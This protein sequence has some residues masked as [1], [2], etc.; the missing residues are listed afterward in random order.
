M[1]AVLFTGCVT[2]N[3]LLA[4]TPFFTAKS[5]YI[6]GV[7]V[8]KERI[9]LIQEKGE[10]GKDLPDDQKRV[11]L[12]QL[13]EEYL[14]SPNPNVREESI[15]SI[16]QLNLPEGYSVIKTATH[17]EIAFVRMAACD[18]LSELKTDETA[19]SLRH[20]LLHDS[21]VDVRHRAAKN[22]AVYKNDQ[23]TI[24]ALGMALDDKAPG[25]QFQAMQ[26]LKKVTDQDFGNDIMRWKQFVNGES[27]D[28][29]RKR[30]MTERLYLNQLPM[31]N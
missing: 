25:V 24:K 9:E 8:P 27:P 23:E 16:K 22:L 4:K 12:E 1:I 13:S 20:V 29:A 6:P 31:F 11:L 21:D 3:R 14:F 10:N 19:H 30:S 28:P 5:D 15:K 2:N 7:L 17:D 26:S 18:A